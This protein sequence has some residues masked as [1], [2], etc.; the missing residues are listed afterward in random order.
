[1]EKTRRQDGG[2][3]D[4]GARKSK[5]KSTQNTSQE[6]C[7]FCLQTSG[8]LHECTTMNLDQSLRSMA[9]ELQDGDLLARVS[10]GD[11]VAIEA[12]YHFEY[13]SGFKSR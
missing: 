1:M 7:M 5:R 3:E 12:K 11:L 13:M 6:S 4:S 10:G 8:K 2:Q 9:K